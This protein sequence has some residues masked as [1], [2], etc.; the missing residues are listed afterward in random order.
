MDC[1]RSMTGCQEAMATEGGGCMCACR[2][3]GMCT[4]RS[5]LR[6]PHRACHFEPVSAAQG[7]EYARHVLH[8]IRPYLA[9]SHGCKLGEVRA[10]VCDICLLPVCFFLSG[11]LQLQAR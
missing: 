9:L 4:C 7:Q 2:C 1:R 5:C 3:L 11:M 10:T 6:K 8:H